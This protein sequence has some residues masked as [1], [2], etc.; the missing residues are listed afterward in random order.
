MAKPIRVMTNCS[1]CGAVGD[2]ADYHPH[3]FCVLVKTLGSHSARANLNA[4]L[5]HGRALERL[6]LPNDASLRA[7]YARAQPKNRRRK[8]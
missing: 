3:A 5:D 1:L 6:G 4:V 2:P 7:V 8:P